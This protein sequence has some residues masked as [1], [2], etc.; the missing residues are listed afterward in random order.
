MTAIRFDGPCDDQAR[1]RAI[2]SGEILV[3]PP[4]DSSLEFCEFARSL[5]ADAF[6]NLE[7]QSAQYRLPVE[8]YARI[9]AVLK[10]KFIHHS[11]SKRLICG[12]L[13]ELGC[14]PLETYFDTP[15]LR[16]STDRKSVV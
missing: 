10:P 12:I 15:R 11:E 1:R 7:P 4:T 6:G 14:D 16:S 8:E 2:Y 3:V 5:I 9:L 13:R